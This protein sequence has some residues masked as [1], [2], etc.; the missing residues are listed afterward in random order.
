MVNDFLKREKFEDRESFLVL[1]NEVQ[2]LLDRFE[3]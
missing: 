1:A 2:F 3:E